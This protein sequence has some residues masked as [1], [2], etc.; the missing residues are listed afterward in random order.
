MHVSIFASNNLDLSDLHLSAPQDSPN[1]DGIK[2]SA[3]QGIRVSHTISGTGDDCVAILNG[4]AMLTLL[5][6]LAALDMES[7]LEESP[8]EGVAS[9]FTALLQTLVTV[10]ES[11]HGNLLMKELLLSVMPQVVMKVTV[12]GKPKDNNCFLLLPP[13]AKE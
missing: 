13:R 1:T 7:V 2:L 5:K 3:S 12:A 9:G 10:Q 11:K 4:I 6:F 8:H